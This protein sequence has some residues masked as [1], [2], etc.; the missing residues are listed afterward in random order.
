GE[1][2]HPVERLPV[3]R[4]CLVANL[5]D[6][7]TT[8]RVVVR[9]PPAVALRALTLHSDAS[10]DYPIQSTACEASPAG[11]RTYRI[12]ASTDPTSARS[13][14]RAAVAAREPSPPTT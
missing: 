5:A 6:V 12:G 3:A 7:H 11:R 10:S 14:G 13:S 1:D 2:S 8:H 9:T 4:C